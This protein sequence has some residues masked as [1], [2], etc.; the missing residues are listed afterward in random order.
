MKRRFNVTGLCIPEKHYM[1][2]ISGHLEKMRVYIEDGEY[3]TVNRA[4]Q[5]GKTTTLNALKRNL[6]KEY[7][8]FLISFE[9][10]EKEVF[11]DSGSFCVRLMGLLYDTVDFGETAGIP[12]DIREEMYRWSM[13]APEEMNFRILTNFFIPHVQTAG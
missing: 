1:A 11:R 2:D 6:E 7:T 12:E 9:G 8:V 3:F 4:R 5:Y 13:S 10:I